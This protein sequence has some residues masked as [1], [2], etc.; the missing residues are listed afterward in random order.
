M[1]LALFADS[2]VF[3][4]GSVFFAARSF[5]ISPL[6]TG[7]DA[8]LGLPW[9]RDSGTSLNADAVF[10]SPTGPF[11]SVID[12]TTRTFSKQPLQN[13][14][15]LG[16]VNTP[17]TPEQQHQMV[18]LALICGITDFEPRPPI[19]EGMTE[20]DTY[21]DYEPHNPLLDIT[22]DDPSLPD[23]TEEEA[24]EEITRL[25]EKYS[26][27]L[28]DALPNTGPPPFRP[29][30]H[31]IPLINPDLII[32]GGVYPCADKWKSQYAAHFNHFTETGYFS[33]EALES[34]CS[35]FAVPKSDPTQARFVINLKPRNANTRKMHTPLPD[36]N[37]IKIEVARHAY[38]SKLDFKN[39]FEQIRI[40]PNDVKHSGMATSFGTFTSKVAQQGDCNSP[41]TMHRVCYMMFRKYI[42]RF[43]DGFYDDWFIYSRTRRAHIRYLNIV[44]AT[45]R[46]YQFYLSKSKLDCFSPSLAALGLVIT[47]DGISV[48]PAKWTKIST[49]PT[50]RCKNDVLRFMG[51]VNWMSD[52]CPRL[53]EIF[54]PL[55][56][57]TGKAPWNWT[58]ACDLAFKMIKDLVPQTLK[59]L[60][61]IKF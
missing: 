38:W 12:L 19:I 7:I 47:D 18:Q 23:L 54:S 61:W 55:T 43:L 48:D 27:I 49:W 8:I 16:F 28:V 58:E 11:E 3:G 50:P 41:E 15:D 37:G 31:S 39:A 32:K 60:D 34:A 30:N 22:D 56:R 13:L 9:I 35:V 5:F 59:P 24:Q 57:L 21:I 29:V 44:F 26:D 1:R 4:S 33:P 20:F 46:H 17:P 14:L 6:P 40:I 42:G 36:M 45:L 53:S 25:T 52:H 10:Y 2:I 51:T